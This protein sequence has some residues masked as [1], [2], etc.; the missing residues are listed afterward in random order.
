[1]RLPAP[2]TRAHPPASEGGSTCTLT[3]PTRSSCAEGYTKALVRVMP[4]PLRAAVRR[5]SARKAPRSQLPARRRRPPMHRSST[6]SLPRPDDRADERSR[7]LAEL[8][9]AEID[10]AGGWIGFERYMQLAL[11]AP[12]LGYYASGDEK[13]GAAGD[14]VTAP[15]LSDALARAMAASLAPVLRAVDEPVVL[16]LG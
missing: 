2:V 5:V 4:R 7:R 15:E 3:L 1:M 6:A 13:L 16:E 10:A 12:D 14:F 8:I 9:R 11:N